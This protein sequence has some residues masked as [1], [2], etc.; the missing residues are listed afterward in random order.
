LV[1]LADNIFVSGWGSTEFSNLTSPVLRYTDQIELVRDAECEKRHEEFSITIPDSIICA[2][3]KGSTDVDA[4][5]GDSGGPL[6]FKTDQRIIL[7]GLVSSGDDCIAEE[8]RKSS[9]IR[10]PGFYTYVAHFRDWIFE[11]ISERGLTKCK[12]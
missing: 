9:G 8:E 4:C 1:F 3:P 11:T 12:V 5:P 2:G 10:K 7:L 6:T